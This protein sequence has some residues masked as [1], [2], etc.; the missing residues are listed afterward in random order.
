MNYA[1]NTGGIQVELTEEVFATALKREIKEG[2]GP[3]GVETRAFVR[4]IT[5]ISDLRIKDLQTIAENSGHKITIVL[6]T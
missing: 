2:G 3:V 5:S 1:T 4:G 6:E